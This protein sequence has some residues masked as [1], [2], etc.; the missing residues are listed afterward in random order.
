MH[1]VV[2]DCKK[3]MEKRIQSLDKDLGRV[4]TG[5]ASVSLLDGIR[6]DYYGTPTPINQVASLATPDARTIV[7]TPFEK[8]LLQDL[9]KAIGYYL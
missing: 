4:R 1:K 6:V 3:D 2:E 7:I 8:K 9:E 5:R